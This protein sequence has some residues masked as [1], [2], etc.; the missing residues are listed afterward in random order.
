MS[1]ESPQASPRMTPHRGSLVRWG[2][3]LSLATTICACSWM[4]L[5]VQAE[6]VDNSGAKMGAAAKKFLASLTPD[7]KSRAQFG[8]YD[9]ERTNW[10]FIPRP[11][12][13]VPLKELEGDSLKSAL[14][15]I[16]TGLS[17]AGYDQALNIMS[18]EEVLYLLEPGDRAERRER[19]DP[20]KYYLSVFGTLEDS[21]DRWGW[22]LEGHHL[23]LNYTI[24]NNKVVSSTPEFFGANPGMID[25]GPKRM[26]RVLAPEEDIARQ[27]LKACTPEQMQVA[28]IN[29]KAPNEIR[30]PGE[31]HG[32]ISNP[33]GLEYSAMSEDQK[34]ILGQLLDEYLKNMPSR[35]EEV[36][37]KEISTAGMEKIKF[38]WW[39]GT[40]RNEPHYY[41][42]QGP[43]F[44]IEYNNVQNDA[45]HVH[46]VWRNVSGDFALDRNA[47]AAK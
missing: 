45:N 13:G 41:R 26:I 37:R 7:Q 6:P 44:L 42:V 33:V 31:L 11:R 35:I 47:Q 9:P 30:S 19:R 17:P 4:L 43:T 3:R 38:A 16:Q 8:S 20:K 34:K 39:G 29:K 36:R 5:S 21:G 18:L 22:R 15:L 10:H 23:S 2:K 46:S 25:A 12:K 40:E 32:D 27:L 24:E 14:E 28:L 1:V